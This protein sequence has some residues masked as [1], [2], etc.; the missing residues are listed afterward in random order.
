M[1]FVRPNPQHFAYGIPSYYGTSCRPQVYLFSGVN[2][3]TDSTE[4]K[5][6]GEKK[7][8]KEETG[9]QVIYKST[10]AHITR[11]DQEFVVTVDLPGVKSKDLKIELE[12]GTLRVSADRFERD[13]TVSRYMRHFTIDQNITDTEKIHASLADGVLRI[14]LPK[15]EAPA[16][17]VVSVE[18]SEAPERAEDDDQVRLSLDMPG[19]K[20]ENLHISFH[21]D[22]LT[23]AAERKTHNG[24]VSKIYRTY[25]LDGNTMKVDSIK[26]YLLDGVLTITVPRKPAEPARLVSV[27]RSIE[28]AT[29]PKP[30]LTASANDSQNV[31][32]ESVA[33]EE[34][35]SDEESSKWHH[36]EDK[37]EKAQE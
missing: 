1:F 27:S 22:E 10:P 36:V 21:N 37:T 19:V 16:K 32:V 12:N 28:V 35:Q 25:S 23:V 6:E 11:S 8:A 3:E 2:D 30:V 17:T 18:A 20:I 34:A 4:K 14:A 33:D 29:E 24:A 13:S 31:V 5:I 7:D 26:A 15:K 9:R